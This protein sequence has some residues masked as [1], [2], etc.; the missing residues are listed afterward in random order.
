MSRNRALYT[1]SCDCKAA[2]VV[3]ERLYIN[4][5]ILKILHNT[6]SPYTD[7]W[8]QSD[9]TQVQ[10]MHLCN[11]NTLTAIHDT[12]CVHGY[13]LYSCHCS[14]KLY[15]FLCIWLPIFPLD[16]IRILLNPERVEWKVQTPYHT[17]AFLSNGNNSLWTEFVRCII[18]LII[19]ATFCWHNRCT[20]VLY[21]QADPCIRGL[22]H[23]LQKFGKL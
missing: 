19:N 18:Q 14:P 12:G 8:T 20:S 11:I 7:M 10:T 2:D 5:L 6:L 17:W 21:I 15:I 13:T 1:L 3:I 16:I 23:P 9:T 4:C 22:P